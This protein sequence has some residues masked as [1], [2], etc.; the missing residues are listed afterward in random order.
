M[1]RKTRSTFE[2]RR[3]EMARQ[4]KQ[5]DKLARR[6]ESK[7]REPG[8]SPAR[9]MGEDPDIAGVRPGPQPLPP[10]WDVANE[11]TKPEEK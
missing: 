10:E 1:A 4:Q 6:L 2:K 3:K 11:V 8:G 7:Q 9:P 5:R